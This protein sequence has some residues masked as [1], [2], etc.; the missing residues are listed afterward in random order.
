MVQSSQAVLEA[1]LTIL[2]T[3]GDH[4]GIHNR[5][6]ALSSLSLIVLFHWQFQ[7]SQHSKKQNWGK[8]KTAETRGNKR[9]K[10]EADG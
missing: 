1:Q 4:E 6:E 10:A 7:M 8:S 9:E 3:D 2:G 5:V